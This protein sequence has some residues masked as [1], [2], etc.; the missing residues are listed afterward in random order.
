MLYLGHA[1]TAASAT[2]AHRAHTLVEATLRAD[3][4]A[5]CKTLGCFLHLQRAHSRKK[6]HFR[7]PFIPPLRSSELAEGTLL[8]NEISLCAMLNT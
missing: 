7:P 2:A 4:C 8:F 5:T 3:S 6:E 1:I